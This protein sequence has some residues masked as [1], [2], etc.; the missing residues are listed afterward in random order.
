MRIGN[1]AIQ[2]KTKFTEFGSYPWYSQTHLI[3]LSGHTHH[4]GENETNNT[5]P[6]KAYEHSQVGFVWYPACNRGAEVK[7]PCCTLVL[8]LLINY[9]FFNKILYCEMKSYKYYLAE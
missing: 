2:V 6:Y 5:R 4:I 8:I 7:T 1:H 3:S 9:I